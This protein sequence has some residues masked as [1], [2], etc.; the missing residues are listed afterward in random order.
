MFYIHPWEIDPEQPRLPVSRMAR[1]RHYTGLNR[2]MP[3][4][5]GC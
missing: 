3:G 4:S 1:F 2:T 5:S